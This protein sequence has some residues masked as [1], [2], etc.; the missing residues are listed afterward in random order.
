[1]EWQKSFRNGLSIRQSEEAVRFV[2]IKIDNVETAFDHCVSKV[3]SPAT[4]DQIGARLEGVII[5][6]GRPCDL[7]V[8]GAQS[9]ERGMRRCRWRWARVNE[10]QAG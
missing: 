4:I 8:A 7:R 6:T 10:S 3:R 1:M 9:R 5:A 2:W